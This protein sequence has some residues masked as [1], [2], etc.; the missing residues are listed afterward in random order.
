MQFSSCSTAGVTA[1]VA[2]GPALML[3]I[4]R[5]VFSSASTGAGHAPDG[6]AF[7]AG[8]RVDRDA[9]RPGSMQLPQV[10][11]RGSRRAVKVGQRRHPRM[12]ASELEHVGG[13][14]DVLRL[15][16]ERQHQSALDAVLVTQRLVD[17]QFVAAAGRRA[18]LPGEAVGEDVQV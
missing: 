10:L 1:V 12:G 16:L 18:Q 7:V 15:A 6:R 2:A 17:R 5:W 13:V 14:A 8:Q 3:T 4:A 11:D 9:P